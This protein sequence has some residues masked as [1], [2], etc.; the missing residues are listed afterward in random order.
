MGGGT[1]DSIYPLLGLRPGR[2]PGHFKV[3]A[4]PGTPLPQLRLRR[5]EGY[6]I[7]LCISHPWG[8]FSKLDRSTTKR[9]P[10]PNDTFSESSRRD[11]SNAERFLA[12][13][14]LQLWRYRPWKIGPGG[15]WCYMH[16]RVPYTMHSIGRFFLMKTTRLHAVGGSLLRSPSFSAA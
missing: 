16:R 7:R 8:V 10:I 4:L 5:T 3:H 13:P 14:P 1:I 11:G 9:V 15:G 12:P 2:L 6:R